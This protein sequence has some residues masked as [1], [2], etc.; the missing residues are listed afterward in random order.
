MLQVKI[1]G[2]SYDFR[3]MLQ[4]TFSDKATLVQVM[5][6]CRQATSHYLSQCWPRFMS[7]YGVTRPQWLIS[8]FYVKVGDWFAGKTNMSSEHK[9]TVTMSV[10]NTYD[11]NHSP[12][13]CRSHTPPLVLVSCCHKSAHTISEIC[14][15]IVENALHTLRSFNIISMTKCKTVESPSLML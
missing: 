9:P 14:S 13:S 6:W 8:L 4:N 1:K 12:L 3:W 7:L 10:Q 2:T 5:A 15:D 11:F